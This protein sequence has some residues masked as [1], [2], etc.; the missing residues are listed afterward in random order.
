MDIQDKDRKLWWLASYPKSGNTWVRMFL[1]AYATGFP[2]DMNSAF[3]L[4]MGDINKNVLQLLFPRPLDTISNAEQFMYHPAMLL[5]MLHLNTSKDVILKTHN[6]KC[7]VEDIPTIPP[8]FTGG[9]VYIIRDPRDL[10]L[11][12]ATHFDISLKE[13][14]KFMNN[15]K[16]GGELPKSKLIHI[17][18]TWSMHV[19]TW[20]EKNEDVP[21]TIIK[22]EDMLDHPEES[23]EKILKAFTFTDINKDRFKFALEATNF[24]KLREQEDERGFREKAGGERFFNFGTHGHWKEKLPHQHVKQIEKDHGEIM[25]KFG[26]E[27]VTLDK[28]IEEY[29]SK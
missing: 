23:F 21:T 29:A 27:P 2:A 19:I 13:A 5:T 24:K 8:G 17:L 9:A 16:Q 22:Y 20:T 14:V 15:I 28:E 26:Y 3:Q 4:A 18:L 12:L 11:S 6:A 1:N 10:V 25:Q 7:K